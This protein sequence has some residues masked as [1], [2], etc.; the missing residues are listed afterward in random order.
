MS[1]DGNILAEAGIFRDISDNTMVVESQ[2]TKELAMAL[3]M[4]YEWVQ[5]PISIPIRCLIVRSR[6]VSKP[7]DF[8]LELSVIARKFDRHIVSTAADVP[9]KFQSDAII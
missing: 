2:A 8:Y 7:Q 3:S 6:K 4:T 1:E 9:V 5:D